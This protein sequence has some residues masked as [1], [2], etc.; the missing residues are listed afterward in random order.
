MKK[1]INLIA[2]CL[3]VSAPLLSIQATKSPLST[4]KTIGI[5]IYNG[6]GVNGSVWV[7]GPTSFSATLI[8]GPNS[9]GPVTA[10]NY[11]VVISSTA[12]PHTYIFYGQT[13]N[14]SSGSA[15][16]FPNITVNAFGSV[17]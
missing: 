2:V 14:N 13:I 10:G 17:N 12:A 8:P 7:S 9:F 11:T 15:T 16:F 3:L 5:N 6:T 4:K 1:I